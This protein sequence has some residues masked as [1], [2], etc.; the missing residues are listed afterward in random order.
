[1]ARWAAKSST[2]WLWGLLSAVEFWARGTKSLYQDGF[3]VFGYHNVKVMGSCTTENRKYTEESFTTKKKISSEKI[4]A[5]KIIK[6]NTNCGAREN[7]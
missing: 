1:M 3:F 2:K 7:S 6:S 5:L 4:A